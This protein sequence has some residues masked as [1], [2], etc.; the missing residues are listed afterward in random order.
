MPRKKRL[1]IAVISILLAV[2]LVQIVLKYNPS[3]ILGHHT[4]SYYHR[5][6]N[7]NDV[8]VAY[9]VDFWLNDTIKTSAT[10]LI[11]RDT[12]AYYK[13]LQDMHFPQNKIDSI[14]KD[15]ARGTPGALTRPCERGHPERNITE[16][17]T[18]SDLIVTLYLQKTIYIFEVNNKKERFAIFGYILS[19]VSE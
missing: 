3:N 18:E 4:S 14:P 16:N 8:S 2:L 11:P 6:A 19:R 15:I 9:V 17:S 7:R 5:Y 10:I 1:C 12:A 13:I